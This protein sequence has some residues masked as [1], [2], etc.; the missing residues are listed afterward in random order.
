MDVNFVRK[1]PGTIIASLLSAPVSVP[2]E[3]ARMAFYAD[4][5]FP[6]EL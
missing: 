1:V 5:T 2:F 4:K 3:Y 6:K